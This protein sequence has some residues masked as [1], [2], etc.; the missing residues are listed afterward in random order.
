[1]ALTLA[2][3]ITQEVD[4]DSVILNDVYPE[5]VWA[6][7]LNPEGLSGVWSEVTADSLASE[8]K[9]I[10][11]GKLEPFDN[12][13]QFELTPELLGGV[14]RYRRALAHCDEKL[15]EHSA[16]LWSSRQRPL[17]RTKR[18]LYETYFNDPVFKKQWHLVSVCERERDEITEYVSSFSV[19]AGELE[20]TWS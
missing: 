14:K 12:V 8:L 4:P 10:N 19:H 6:V 16:V 5:N 20:G 13:F 1:M 18:E 3:R 9:L 7:K 15:R 17:K 11:R 2:V